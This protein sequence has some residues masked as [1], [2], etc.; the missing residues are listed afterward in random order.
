M[1]Q[2]IVSAMVTKGMM[3]DDMTKFIELKIHDMYEN[4]DYGFIC[5]LCKNG[6]IP[7]EK[8]KK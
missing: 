1:N 7:C 5:Y 4:K 6:K 3:K 8:H 2:T